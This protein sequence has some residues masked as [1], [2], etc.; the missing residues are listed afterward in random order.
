MR[1]LKK[2]HSLNERFNKDLEN[3]NKYDVVGSFRDYVKD[4][5]VGDTVECK[6]YKT[7]KI[8]KFKKMSNGNTISAFK[9]LNGNNTMASPEHVFGWM[10][11]S[12][13]YGDYT[14]KFE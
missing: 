8:M 13:L 14:P 11:D 6:N 5:K 3:K 1:V 7:G 2:E 4:M 10:K 12:I 9:D